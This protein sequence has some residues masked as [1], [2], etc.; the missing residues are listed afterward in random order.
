MNQSKLKVTTC[1]GHK[2]KARENLCQPVTIG[3]GFTSDWIRKCRKFFFYA[4]GNIKKMIMSGHDVGKI[5]KNC[6][7]CCFVLYAS[8]KGEFEIRLRMIFLLTLN[9]TFTRIKYARLIFLQFS[10]AWFNTW[11]TVRRKK[12]A[13]KAGR[14]WGEQK[15]KGRV[16]DERIGRL[17][18]FLPLPWLDL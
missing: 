6:Q 8:K 2:A 13:S 4:N 11:N 1:S 9:I 15:R 17:V 12:I 10:C 16:G 14:D 3:T 5:K 18:P 7:Y